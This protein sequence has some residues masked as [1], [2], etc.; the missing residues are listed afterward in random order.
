MIFEVRIE[1]VPGQRLSVLRRSTDNKQA[2]LIKLEISG[3]IR[4][5]TSNRDI[6]RPDVASR[7]IKDISN[8]YKLRPVRLSIDKAVDIMMVLRDE[9]NK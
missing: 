7:S 5:C 8:L 1:C 9:K 4:R 3:L 2:D 6:E